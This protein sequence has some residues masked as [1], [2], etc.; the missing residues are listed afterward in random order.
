MLV[1]SHDSHLYALQLGDDGKLT[2][3]AKTRL[4][5]PIAHSVTLTDEG[6][7]LLTTNQ[8]IYALRGHP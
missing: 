8:N 1:G 7:A 3:K 2:E 5:G 6:F 4:D